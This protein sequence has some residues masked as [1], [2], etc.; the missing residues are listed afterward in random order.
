MQYNV[1]ANLKEHF[2]DIKAVEGWEICVAK[3]WYPS[4]HTYIFQGAR[5]IC[6]ATD[7]VRG[8]IKGVHLSD[9]LQVSVPKMNV[10]IKVEISLNVKL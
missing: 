9:F 10:L 2:S 1:F 4:I 7:L 8:L 3:D 5:N 6:F